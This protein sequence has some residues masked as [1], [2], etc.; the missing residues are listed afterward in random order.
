[1]AEAMTVETV[2]EAYWQIQ[3][4]WTK[5][6][7]PFQTENN[8]WSDVDVLAFHPED[9]HLVVAESKVHTS[10]KVVYAYVKQPFSK[11]YRILKKGKNGYE[12]VRSGSADGSES[13]PYLIYPSPRRSK[14]PSSRRR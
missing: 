7:F 4:Y 1:M 11:V 12:V 2:V 10:K 13:R 9:Q 6:R 14:S 5:L 8:A 3:G